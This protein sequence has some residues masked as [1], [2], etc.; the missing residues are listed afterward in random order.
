MLRTEGL[1]LSDAGGK[2]TH[3]LDVQSQD[4]LIALSPVSFCQRQSPH[5][6]GVLR[7]GSVADDKEQKRRSRERQFGALW[8][9]MTDGE[10]GR[11][12]AGENGQPAPAKLRGDSI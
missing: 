1:E 3:I 11:F 9:V 5:A 7:D 2:R 6:R 10:A 12:V 8:Q 4:S